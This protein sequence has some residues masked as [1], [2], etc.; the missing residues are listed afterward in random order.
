MREVDAQQ[1]SSPEFVM[2]K[3]KELASWDA[4]TAYDIVDDHG[5]RT[6]TCRWVLVYKLLDDGTT[7]PK[8]R[9]VVR[10]FQETGV[11]D[12]HTFSPTCSKSSWRVLLTVAVYKGSAPV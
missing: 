9:L 12:V 11:Q 10:R 8:A 3:Q 6:I 2:A 7:K 4:C 5:Q 1:A